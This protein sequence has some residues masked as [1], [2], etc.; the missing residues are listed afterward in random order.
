[1]HFFPL[2]S[3]TFLPSLLWSKPM[4]RVSGCG[5]VWTGPRP[6]PCVLPAHRG[7]RR[8]CACCL[9]F[10]HPH[11]HD[12]RDGDH[13][14]PP[15]GPHA[16]PCEQPRGQTVTAHW[17]CRTQ[18]HGHVL[19]TAEFIAHKEEGFYLTGLE[20]ILRCRY[21]LLFSLWVENTSLWKDSFLVLG[22]SFRQPVT[23]CQRVGCAQAP[24][25]RPLLCPPLCGPRPPVPCR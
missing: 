21:G 11:S 17:L 2:R 8:A 20:S 22:E 9:H 14:R 7:A 25:P 19:N 1:M 18:I 23:G 3:Q 16:D 6:C 5:G 13:P 15:P 24:A 10:R 12:L 4:F